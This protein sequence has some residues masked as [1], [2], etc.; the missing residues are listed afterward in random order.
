[1]TH[2]LT[3]AGSGIGAALARALLDRGDELVLLARSEERAA[4]LAAA[5]DGSRTLVADLADPAALERA[6]AAAALPDRLDSLVHA[7]GVVDLSPVEGLD[8]AA[9]QHQLD[10]NLTAPM[11]V[12]RACLP[13]LRAARGTVV[14]VNSGSGL[15]ANPTW[16]AYAAS[17]FGLRALAD[18]LRLEEEPHGVRVTGVHPGRVSTPMQ[19]RVHAQEGKEYDAG[20]W[21]DPVTVADSIRHVL[22]LPRD[23]TVPELVLR[24]G[25]GTGD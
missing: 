21:S 2:L 22:D 13:A 19:E 20:A 12:T 25:P 1:M 9:W 7:A 3:G 6:L 5:Y 11:L 18:A 10:V 16:A 23:S 15:R 14:F 4:E 8:L 17:K 24:P